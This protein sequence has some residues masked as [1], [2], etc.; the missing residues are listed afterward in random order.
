M[1]FIR[2]DAPPIVIISGDREIELYGR[3]EEQA[4]FW[5]ML[6]LVGHPDATLYEMQGYSHGDMA[7]PAFHILK[8]TIK[9]LN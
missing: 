3:Y 8:Q 9:R 7:A 2:K 5:R 1:T 6:K 4:F